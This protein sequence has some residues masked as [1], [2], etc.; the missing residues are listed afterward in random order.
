MEKE[1]DVITLCKKLVELTNLEICS[2]RETSENNRYKLSLKNGSIEIHH[3]RPA[4]IDFLNAEYYDVSLFDNKAERY[5]TY[6]A[7][8]TDGDRYKVFYNLY[9][10]VLKLLEKIRRRKIALLFEEL[11]TQEETKK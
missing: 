6:K 10:A 3:F 11:E 8:S 4:D 9:T 7:T 1:V 5:A 2:W